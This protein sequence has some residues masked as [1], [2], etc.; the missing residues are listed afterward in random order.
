M[1]SR[2]KSSRGINLGDSIRFRVIS[3]YHNYRI[4]ERMVN[5]FAGDR[6]TVRYM[7]SPDYA[8]KHSEII[9]VIPA[10]AKRHGV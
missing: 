3:A 1:T 8:V 10:V 5:G 6:P 4:E 7:G 9:K 2:I